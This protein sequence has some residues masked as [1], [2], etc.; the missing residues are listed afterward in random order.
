MNEFHLIEAFLEMM[1]A[2]RGAAKNTLE[3]YLRDLGRYHESVVADGS[4][5]SECDSEHV[6]NYLGKL[7]EE[8]MSASTQ[9]RHLSAIRQFH[10]FLFSEG[11]RQ[12]DPTGNLDSPKQAKPLPK[13]MSVEEVDRL[14]GLAASEMANTSVS[15]AK[16]VRSARL[17]CLVE[18]LYATGLRVSELVSMPASAA[19]AQGRFLTIVGKGRKE[20]IVPVSEPARQAVAIYLERKKAK[21]NDKQSPFLFPASSSEGHFTRQAFARDL[22]ELA[23]RAGLA[24]SKVSP[25]V[26]RHAFAS[27]LLQNGADLRVVQQLLGHSDIS[28]TQIYTHVLDERLKALVEEH[29]PLVK[30]TRN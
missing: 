6:R 4:R 9:A 19:N 29:H 17:Y 23:L 25:H 2:E 7:V 20:R 16:Q 24:V 5:L 11:I 1:N 10:K 22:K 28:T 8:G 13:I 12:D 26:L 21:G 14:I 3:S 30:L 18:L 27:H 15:P